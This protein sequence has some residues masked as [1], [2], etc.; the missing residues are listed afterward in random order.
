MKNRTAFAAIALATCGLTSLTTTRAARACGGCFHETGG[1]QNIADITDERMLL[2]VSQNQ[3]TLY[4]QIRYSG[5]PASFAWVLPIKGTVTVGLSADVLFDSMDALTATQING[6]ALNC[7]PPPN[8][9]GGG[10]GFSASDESTSGFSNSGGSGDSPPPVTVT[11]Q[12]NVGPYE[13]VQLHT[14]DPKALNVWL[15]TNGFTIP[16]DVTATIDAYVGEGFDFLAMKLLPGEGIQA[17]RPVR[18]TM[19][20]SSMTLPL[21]MAAVGTGTAVGITLW[22]VASGRYEPQNFPFFHIDD[23]N[24]IWD[25]KTSLS[26]YTTLRQADEALYFGK[27][28]EIES[29]INLNS[30]IIQNAILSGGANTNGSQ[31]FG[32]SSADD[33]YLAIG[34]PNPAPSVDSGSAAASDGGEDAGD[35][36]GT[37]I[38]AGAVPYQSASDVRDQDLRT[39]LEAASG[40]GI[41]R[42]TR[43]RSDISHAAMST[44]LIVQ[45]SSDQSEVTNVRLVTKSVNAPACPTYAAC[46]DSSSC[47]TSSRPAGG[48]TGLLVT[49]LSMLGLVF[50]RVIRVRRNRR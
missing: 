15:A 19:P 43:M 9:G 20:G 16:D 25:W 33:D 21:R 30:A 49:V 44:D 27:G 2:S 32:T 4:D 22:V 47:D 10:C 6:P 5:N 29:S 17:M 48:G 36:G 8:C 45:A 26:N 11:K 28:W 46:S 1:Q 38:D 18:V 24:L 37:S 34:D 13:T 14:T 23:A 50:T 41:V 31:T 35:D 42:V 12:Q 39:L 7:P 3:T 40:S